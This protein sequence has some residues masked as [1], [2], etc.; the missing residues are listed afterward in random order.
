MTFLADEGLDF[1]VVAL[2]RKNGFSVIYAAEEFVAASDDFLLQ[3]AAKENYILITKDKDFGD[4]V[5]RHKKAS[6]GIILIRIEKLN[7]P[8]NC[9]LIVDVIRKYSHELAN[10]FTVIQQDKIRI[11][12]YESSRNRHQ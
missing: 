9:Q 3:I 2:L 11:R 4:M 12:T 6:N 8:S 7:V 5:I 10:S 1:P